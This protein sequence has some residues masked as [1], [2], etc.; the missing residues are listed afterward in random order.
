[1]LLVPE[2]A[3]TDLFRVHLFVLQHDAAGAAS[4]LRAHKRACGLS[5][6]SQLE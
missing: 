6:C 5:A 1:M 3:A 2:E 4:G